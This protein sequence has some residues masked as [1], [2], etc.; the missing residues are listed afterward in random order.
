MMQ[1]TVKC[2]VGGV[3]AALLA[4]SS[5][6]ALQECTSSC[7]KLSITSPSSANRG[8]PVTIGVEFA[9]GP[10][11]GQAG[12]GNDE[13]AALA[14]SIGLQQGTGTS[15]PLT[16]DCTDTNSDGLPDAVKPSSAIAN[17]KVVVENALCTNRNRCLCPSSNPADGQTR[18]SFINIVV[19]GPK[20]LPSQAPVDIPVLPSGHLLDIDLRVADAATAP[21]TLHPFRETDSSPKP[22][23]AAFCSQGDKSAVDQ[24]ADRGR[25]A[26]RSSSS[27]P[28]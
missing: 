9:Q 4:S 25:I 11:D 22:Q 2:V 27:M 20:E 14:F 17:F 18:D 8:G 13:I 3:A 10:D 15:A 1:R 26:V 16:F 19:Y 24:T 23:F 5:A 7:S 12:K 6:P 28:S 21:V